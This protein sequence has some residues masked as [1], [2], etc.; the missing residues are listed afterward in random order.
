MK[1]YLKES[2]LSLAYFILFLVI[3]TKSNDVIN[4]QNGASILFE[5]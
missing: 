2:K 1:S 5:V 4:S 3:L